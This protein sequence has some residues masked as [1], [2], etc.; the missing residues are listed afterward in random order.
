MSRPCPASG[1]YAAVRG[2]ATKNYVPDR[3]EMLRTFT[4]G[5]FGKKEVTIY[6]FSGD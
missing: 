3:E 6:S 4:V 5:D 2:A 1:D